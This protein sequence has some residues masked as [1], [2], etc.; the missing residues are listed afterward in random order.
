MDLWTKC[1]NGRPTD[2]V[3]RLSRHVSKRRNTAASPVA[4]TMPGFA[5][6]RLQGDAV[7][8]WI[9]GGGGIDTLSLGNKPAA[10]A[11][12]IPATVHGGGGDGEHEEGGSSEGGSGGSSETNTNLG[13]MNS[14]GGALPVLRWGYTT[15]QRILPY[16]RLHSGTCL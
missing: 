6:K 3:S 12:P 16:S 2:P 1:V 8:C 4:E 10:A 11:A 14:G 5:M 13:N 7:L 15:C 9:D